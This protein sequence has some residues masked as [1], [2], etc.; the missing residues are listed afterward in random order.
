ME[1][2]VSNLHT[3]TPDCCLLI[4]IADQLDEQT[5]ILSDSIIPIVDEQ[6]AEFIDDFN[7]KAV[8]ALKEAAKALI[9]GDEVSAAKYRGIAEGLCYAVECAIGLPFDISYI[10]AIHQAKHF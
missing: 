3:P 7:C 10:A 1:K 8:R 9:D 5:G 2:I 6:I 4:D